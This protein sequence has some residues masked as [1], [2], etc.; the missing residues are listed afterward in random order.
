MATV[1]SSAVADAG[2]AWTALFVAVVV[3]QM[4]EPGAGHRDEIAGGGSVVGRLAHTVEE[5]LAVCVGVVVL[6]R[7]GA[8]EAEMM[9]MMAAK[10]TQRVPAADY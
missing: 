7:S 9:M 1:A 6:K 8:A 3:E 2:G 5:E 10:V 4:A